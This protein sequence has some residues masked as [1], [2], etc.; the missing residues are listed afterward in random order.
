MLN[1]VDRLLKQKPIADERI[2]YVKQR[3]DSDCGRA[4]LCMMGYDGYQMFSRSGGIRVDK[5][6]KKFGYTKNQISLIEL[7]NNTFFEEPHFLTVSTMRA[8]QWGFLAVLHAVIGYKDQIYCPSLG[9]FK[10]SE[11]TKYIWGRTIAGF[12]VPF[13]YES[14]LNL[15]RLT[16]CNSQRVL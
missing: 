4:C 1:L 3:D 7:N 16:P 13:A 9:I 2:R 6:A 14:N 11:Y 8:E 10:I 15:P 5:V 12:P